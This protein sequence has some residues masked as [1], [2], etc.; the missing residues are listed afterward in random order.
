MSKMQTIGLIG[1]M[2]WQS[3]ALY[4]RLVN[5][6]VERR[7]GGFHSAQTL[8][9]SVDFAEVEELQRAGRWEEA[10]SLLVGAARRLERGGADFL[11]LC[12][13]TMHRMADE[14][15]AA[16]R[17]PLLHIADATATAIRARGLGTVGLLGTRYTM[18]GEFYRGR[19]EACH[20]L[21]VLVPSEPG[22]SRIHDVIY[23]ELV[24]GHVDAASREAY[25]A[26]MAELVQR[27]SEA[28]ILGCTEITMLVSENDA[29]VPIFDTTAIHAEQAVDWALT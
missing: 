23:D 27:G 8:M 1:G 9:Y 12:T 19:L 20:G 5:E 29:T 4:Y 17:I 24:R 28:V 6:G 15:S 3:S 18:Q 14:L 16:V 13:N 2:S 26:V 10:T 11:V 25:R 7:L 22:H 21:K